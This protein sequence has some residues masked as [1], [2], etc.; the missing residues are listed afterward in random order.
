MKIKD[1]ELNIGQLK[2]IKRL[3]R[4]LKH[5]AKVNLALQGKSDMLVA[6]NGTKYDMACDKGLVSF[7]LGNGRKMIPHE[8]VEDYGVY[9]DSGADD[10]ETIKGKHKVK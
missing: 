3:E 8:R 9:R 6:Y 2:A 7:E 5:C 4:A 10:F 1:M